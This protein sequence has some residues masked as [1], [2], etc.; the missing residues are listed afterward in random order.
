MK[1]NV[2]P[3]LVVSF[4]SAALFTLP[5]LM[6]KTKFQSIVV[7]EGDWQVNSLQLESIQEAYNILPDNCKRIYK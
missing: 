1:S 6:I 7:N 2:N 5:S 3:A 4:Y